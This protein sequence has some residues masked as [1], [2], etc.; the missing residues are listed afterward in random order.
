MIEVVT[1]EKFYKDIKHALLRRAVPKDPM[2]H[3]SSSSAQ[4]WLL[5][6]L[7]AAV[8]PLPPPYRALGC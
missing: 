3:R 7:L 8:V 4:P 5:L 1:H 6:A 2:T